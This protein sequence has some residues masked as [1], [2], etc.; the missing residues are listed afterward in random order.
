MARDSESLW[1]RDLGSREGFCLHQKLS[2]HPKVKLAASPH[3]RAPILA[4]IGP[5][6]GSQEKR[7]R[8]QSSDLAG[9]GCP[10]EGDTI[11]SSLIL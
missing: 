1:E 6:G 5:A 11:G 2:K 3:P 9:T 7:Q 8:A 4:G 10:G